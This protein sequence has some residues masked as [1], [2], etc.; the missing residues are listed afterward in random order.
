MTY[1]V[2]TITPSEYKKLSPSMREQ[3]EQQIAES[4]AMQRGRPP[5][6]R[7]AWDP[8]VAAGLAAGFTTEQIGA[9]LG[10]TGRSVRMHRPKS[11]C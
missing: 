2:Q 9:W 3:I 8:I 5:T 4:E 1:E 7:S 11:P 10:V 6:W